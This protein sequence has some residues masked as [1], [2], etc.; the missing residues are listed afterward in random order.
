MNHWAYAQMVMCPTCGDPARFAFKTP[1]WRAWW[2]PFVLI[3]CARHR[4][5]AFVIMH[6]RRPASIISRCSTDMRECEQVRPPSIDAPEPHL[7]RP[8]PASSF[9][10]ARNRST[11]II[12]GRT[13]RAALLRVTTAACC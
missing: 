4:T 6:R 7:H 10:N 9:S 1:V 12:M 3:V 11:T 13:H 8:A 2:L 5:P